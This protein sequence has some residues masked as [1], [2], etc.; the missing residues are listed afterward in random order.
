M[1][2]EQ[3]PLEPFGTSAL[4]LSAQDAL[5]LLERNI[6]DYAIFML[7]PAGYVVSW[8]VGAERII[9]Y[10]EQEIR[11][12]HFSTFYPPEDLAAGKPARE[13]E[14]AIAEGRVEDEGWRVRKDGTRYW[15]DVVITALFDDAGELRGFGKVTRD[16]TERRAAEE[17]LRASEERF[18]LLVQDVTDYAIFMLDP[19]GH[20][21]SWNAGA[22][23]IK[24]Y[25]E[26]EIRGKH[27]SMFY[28][29]EDIAAGRPEHNLETALLE[30]RVEDE[31]WRVR[32]DGTRFWANVVITALYGENRRLRGFSKVTRDMTERRE[33]E[34]SLEE[35]RQLLAHLIRVQ[36]AERLR[37][38][39]ELN[40]REVHEL[41]ELVQS[42]REFA[43]QL[44]DPYA[45][46]LSKL[47]DRAETATEELRAVVARLRPP[48]IDRSSLAGA[49]EDYLAANAPSW[50]LSY[51]VDS[52]LD[53]EPPHDVAV[54]IFRICQEALTNVHKHARAKKVSVALSHT[55]SGVLTR[56]VDDGVG[57]SGPTDL[58]PG[59]GRYGAVEMRE[60]AETVGGWWSMRRN[61][62]GTLV[63]FW[64]PVPRRRGGGSG[65]AA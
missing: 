45:A 35:R 14:I 32:K 36:E 25:T 26:Q 4:G 18:R 59:S 10:T 22:E 52:R 62:P 20:V 38:A 58:R 13:L 63:E 48:G 64:I 55:G 12:K 17:A 24:G 56:V 41:D 57:I 5:H 42:Q 65:S 46:Q 30:G 39:A 51:T 61:E 23:R 33:A 28:P 60:R 16:V 15:S 8:N 34:Q 44:P 3:P 43:E 27:F 1:A 7:D 6:R 21:V 2:S 9:G 40:D 11:G 53:S 37:I 50:G 47:V 49:L 31:G 54:T 19:I 29:P